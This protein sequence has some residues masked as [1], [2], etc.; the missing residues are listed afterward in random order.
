MESYVGD[1]PPRLA[2][3][4][5]AIFLAGPPG[6]GKTHLLQAKYRQAAEAGQ[7]AF[8]F[9]SLAQHGPALLSGLERAATVCLDDVHTVLPLAEWQLPLLHLFN[10]MAQRGG[11]LLM[12]SRL[13]LGRLEVPLKDL[14]SRLKAAYFLQSAPLDD[15]R[16]LE[17]IRRKAEARGFAMSREV[18]RF[19]LERAP[20]DM[21]HLAQLVERLDAETL[22]Q[23]KR[24]TIPFVKSALGL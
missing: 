1:L 15:C 9:G 24:V 7:R 3:L 21:H 19:I 23:Q 22:R 10:G 8:C 4:E 20:R 13:P 5:G 2:Q 6:S 12:A 17:V 11:A 16:K 14:E 18:C